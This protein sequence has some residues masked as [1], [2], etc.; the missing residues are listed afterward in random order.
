MGY[1]FRPAIRESV[2]LL[3]GLIGQSGA[4]KTFSAMRLASGIVG[5]GNK[6]A[7]IDT[8]AR[9]AL[10]YADK[11]KFDHCELSPPFKS[12]D[13]ADVIKA[14]DTAGY[15]AIV[16][17]SCSHEWAGEGG[18]LDFQEAELTRMA[19]DDY[20]KRE[21]CKMA[22]W[23]K[24]KMA[25]K[26]MVQRL[27]QTKAHLILCFR[28]EEKTKIEKVIKDG[29]E[30]T[31]I[32]PI[33]FQPVCSKEMPYELTVSFLLSSDHPGIGQP[34]KL[35]EQHKIIF[36]SGKLIDEIAGAS[37]AEWAAG[38]VKQQKPEKPKTTPTT[39]AQKAEIEQP[40][41][42]PIQASQMA[43]IGKL[44][45]G[46]GIVEKIDMDE[47]MAFAVSKNDAALADKFISNFEE[48]YTAYNRMRDAKLNEEA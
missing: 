1:Q 43:T 25:H 12:L 38:G 27:L 31:V 8:E 32:I 23:I 33:G 29:K 2:G 22:A 36:P 39:P 45:K 47:F 48:F 16:V 42:L 34:I 17:D 9:R 3:I 40:K 20:K 18:V 7:V 24:P 6:F 46:K 44:M 13:Y 21:A 19:G 41:A 5:E 10:H 4:G 26:Q 14:A 30:K 15:K 28:A 11:F 37:V 35:Q